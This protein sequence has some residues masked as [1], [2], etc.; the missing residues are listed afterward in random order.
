MVNSYSL[1]IK[2]IIKKIL[3]ISI[4]SI[5]VGQNTPEENKYI[6]IQN[7]FKYIIALIVPFLLSVCQNKS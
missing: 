2:I 4:V 3:L 5:A 1:L 6:S 7:T